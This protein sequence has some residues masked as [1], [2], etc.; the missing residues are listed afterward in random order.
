MAAC[1]RLRK[2]VE[3]DFNK[4]H[5]NVNLCQIGS[6]VCIL[7]QLVDVA[8]LVESWSDACIAAL[9]AFAND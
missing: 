1:Y 9:M 7:F 6:W 3:P 8:G 5:G 4:S 2:G